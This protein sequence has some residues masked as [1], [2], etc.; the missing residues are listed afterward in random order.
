MNE[1]ASGKVETYTGVT[2]DKFKDRLGG[3]KH[4][5][6]PSKNRDNTC[7][8]NQIWNLKDKGIN[9]NIRFRC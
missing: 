7:L 2:G 1:A 8:S 4:D 3:H 9:H 5:F 6:K